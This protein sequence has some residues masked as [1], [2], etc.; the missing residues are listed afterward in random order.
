MWKASA[1]TAARQLAATEEALAQVQRES[2]ELRTKYLAAIKVADVAVEYVDFKGSVSD[3]MRL[4]IVLFHATAHYR[5]LTE[6]PA[7]QSAVDAVPERLGDD[8]KLEEMEA[9][10]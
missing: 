1:D 10:Q 6:P 7:K 9:K 4:G 3:H 2:A 5:A 8:G